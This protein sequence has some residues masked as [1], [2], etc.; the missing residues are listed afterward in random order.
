MESVLYIDRPGGGIGTMFSLF[1]NGVRFGELECC[2]DLSGLCLLGPFACGGLKMMFLRE[3]AFLI[4][5]SGFLGKK[6][7]LCEEDGKET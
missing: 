7:E 2:A 3:A 5:R 6:L 4:G 1:P